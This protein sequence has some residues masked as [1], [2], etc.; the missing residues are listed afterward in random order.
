MIAE[1]CEYLLNSGSSEREVDAKKE[2][3]RNVCS[4][5]IDELQNQKLTESESDDLEKQAEN[6]NRTITDNNIRNMNILAGV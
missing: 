4:L 5:N 1:F 3:I 6:V 2:M